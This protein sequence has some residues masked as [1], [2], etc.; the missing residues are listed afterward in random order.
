MSTETLEGSQGIYAEQATLSWLTGNIKK[1]SIHGIR[2]GCEQAVETLQPIGKLMAF[3]GEGTNSRT[4]IND[5]CVVR[6]GGQDLGKTPAVNTDRCSASHVA[7]RSL[8]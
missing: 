1:S 4:I 3:V 5:R 8:G 6:V 2:F 7:D